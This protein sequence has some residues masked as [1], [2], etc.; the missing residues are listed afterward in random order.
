M[1][2]IIQLI[3]ICIYIPNTPINPLRN[4]NEYISVQAIVAKENKNV[5]NELIKKGFFLPI[6][7]AIYPE[8]IEPVK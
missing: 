7:S 1:V 2:Q 3:Y 6:L 8:S 5:N 4:S